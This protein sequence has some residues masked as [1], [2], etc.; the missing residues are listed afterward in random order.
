MKR[1]A[2]Q[3][4]V[5]PL[6]QDSRHTRAPVSPSS[7]SRSSWA[8]GGGGGRVC[9]CT[10]RGTLAALM[11]ASVSSLATLILGG[12]II[13]RVGR[14]CEVGPGG[15][16]AGG[17]GVG[18]GGS[19]S[20]GYTTRGFFAQLTGEGDVAPPP[21]PSCPPAYGAGAGA[22]YS[23][24]THGDGLA[25]AMGASPWDELTLD[26]P[27]D[28]QS[29]EAGGAGSGAFPHTAVDPGCPTFVL[30]KY[31]DYAGMGH[32]LSNWVMGLVAAIS[33]PATLLHAPLDYASKPHYNYTGLDAFLGVGSGEWREDAAMAVYPNLSRVDLPR[34]D[35]YS[36]MAR[37]G[38]F[39]PNGRVAV[40]RARKA[41]LTR[42]C[43]IM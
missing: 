27:F 14:F 18:G 7:A 28:A 25:V 8:A 34:M 30:P 11:A 12:R 37:G 21:L 39:S 36:S 6:T 19:G 26:L 9:R 2:S 17:A 23:P 33:L 29:T 41:E 16:W 22:A 3:L 35:Q 40:W 38:M 15:R 4:G 13:G 5:A 42:K 1:T 10:P 20:A 31:H 43:F 32:R 24:P